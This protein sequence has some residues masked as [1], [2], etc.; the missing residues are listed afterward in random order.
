MYMYVYIYIYIHSIVYI[1][2]VLYR[3]GCLV[4]DIQSHKGS[5]DFS[6]APMRSVRWVEPDMFWV[7]LPPFIPCCQRGNTSL[8]A[9]RF[10]V[11]TIVT[12]FIDHR[13]R[14]K[15]DIGREAPGVFFGLLYPSDYDLPPPPITPR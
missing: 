8:L 12:Q 7:H 6:T 5:A 15:S 4:G 1:Y 2:I 14:S 13:S 9:L 10:L 11:G 3:F